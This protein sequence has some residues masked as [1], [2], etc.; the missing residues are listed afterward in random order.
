MSIQ[1]I[2]KPSILAINNE[3]ASLTADAFGGALIDFHLNESEINPLSFRFTE[4]QMPQNNKSGAPFQGHFLCL[5]RWGQPSVGEIKAGIPDHGHFANMMWSCDLP[6]Q[7]TLKMQ[8]ESQLEGL[9][10]ERTIQMDKRL[11]LYL[12]NETVT[13]INPLGRLYNMVQHPTLAAPFLNG[14]TKIQCNALKGFHY[15]HYHDPEK[16]A[17]NWPFGVGENMAMTDLRHCDNGSPSVFS[18]IVD[19]DSR[20]GWITAYSRDAQL[21]IGYLWLRDDYQWINLWKDWDKGRIKYCG[22]EFGTTGVHQPFMEVLERGKSTIFNHK[23]V[24]YIDAGQAVRRKYLSFLVE[25]T[26]DLSE[27]E[28]VYIHNGSLF[29][30]QHKN[31]V[32]IEMNSPFAGFLGEY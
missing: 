9:K 19:E 16:Y 31:R 24:H 26:G 20:F 11:A 3:T 1:G 5:G 22:L 17:S 25:T 18:F 21:L 30:R 8:A 2:I 6:D 27:I 29:I 10:V 13:N 28:S 15:K 23:T 7:R 14:K 12:V 4:D 32:L